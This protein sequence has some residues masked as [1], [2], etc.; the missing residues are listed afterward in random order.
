M[1]IVSTLCSETS[2]SR[3]FLTQ[4]ADISN[5]FLESF[6][7]SWSKLVP[8]DKRFIVLVLL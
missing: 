7:S 1:S 6:D 3:T 5:F 8:L 2:M 4:V